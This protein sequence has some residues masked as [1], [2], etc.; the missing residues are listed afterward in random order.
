MYLR[1]QNAKSG[2]KFRDAVLGDETRKRKR[3]DVEQLPDVSRVEVEEA[4]E[5]STLIIIIIIIFC[6]APFIHKMQLRVLHKGK[7]INIIMQHN[8]K[9]KH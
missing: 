2:Q 8:I 9:T 3:N 4:R 7:Y 5:T 1:S 6:L